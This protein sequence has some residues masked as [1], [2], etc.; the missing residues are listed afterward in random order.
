MTGL[1]T[2]YLGSDVLANRPETPN[3]VEGALALYHATDT[4]EIFKWNN[5]ESAWE[6][7]GLQDP[8]EEGT[9]F[10][11][12]GGWQL[13]E[14]PVIPA[15]PVGEAPEDGESYLRKDGGWVQYEEPVIPAPGIPDAPSDG[16]Q[17]ARQDGAWSPIESG[18]GTADFPP[19]AGNA[20]RVLGVNDGEDGVEWIEQSE[21]GGGEGDAVRMVPSVKIQQAFGRQAGT[22]V[23]AKLAQNPTPGNVLVA[24]WT[25]PASG[26]RLTFP[27]GWKSLWGD[28]GR[29][30]DNISNNVGQAG[31]NTRYLGRFQSFRMGYRVVQAG[32]GPSCTATISGNSDATNLALFELDK[33]DFYDL[34]ISTVDVLGGTWQQVPIEPRMAGAALRFAFMEVDQANNPTFDAA[35]GLTTLNNFHESSG[36]LNHRGTI[37]QLSSDYAQTVMTGSLGGGNYASYPILAFASFSKLAG[38]AVPAAAVAAVPAQYHRVLVDW[39]PAN[40]ALTTYICIAELQFLDGSTLLSTG[41]S[42]IASNFYTSSW[43]PA[44]AFDGTFNSSSNGWVSSEGSLRGAWLGYVTPGLV[45]PKRIGIAPIPGNLRQ[46]FPKS[47]AVQYSLDRGATWMTRRTI[48]LAAAVDN[49]MQFYDL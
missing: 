40:L 12:P 18:G 35:A 38:A 22:T 19:L 3:I 46:Y 27:A 24:M 9:Y 36:S 33:F 32:D 15:P 4:G 10:R 34:D 14:P 26:V 7:F 45:L 28:G 16:T 25:G 6:L 1:L 37:A 30:N 47:I 20:G 31:N 49:Q 48:D 21:G 43:T 8:L 42:P 2:Q 11:V 44:S 5:D 23:T 39:A 17:Y 13:Y 29:S 41:G